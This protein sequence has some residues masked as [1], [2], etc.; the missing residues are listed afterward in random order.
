LAK[1]VWDAYFGWRDRIRLETWKIRITELEQRLSQFYWPLYIRLRRDDLIWKKVFRDL[2]LVGDHTR[3][4]WVHRF[5]EADRLK[6]LQ[7]MEE[8]VLLPNH[9]EAVGIIRSGIHRANADQEFERM[10]MQYI[11]HVDA[12]ASLWS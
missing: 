8:K 1:T 6:L 4:D 11:R 10:L 12:Y 5:S 9:A 3:P 7:E 2:R